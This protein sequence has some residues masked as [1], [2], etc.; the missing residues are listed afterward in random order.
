[1]LQKMPNNI[2]KQQIQNIVKDI[3]RFLTDKNLETYIIKK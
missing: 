1:M 2:K 3:N